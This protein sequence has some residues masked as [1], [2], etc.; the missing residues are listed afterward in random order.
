MDIKGLVLVRVKV[1]C[2]PC[3][4]R[5]HATPITI[6][7]AI[8]L[9]VNTPHSTSTH[10]IALEPLLRHMEPVQAEQYNAEAKGDRSSLSSRQHRVENAA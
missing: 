7:I 10:P 1:R 4:E 2:A 3:R 5:P 6:L 9:M 8:N